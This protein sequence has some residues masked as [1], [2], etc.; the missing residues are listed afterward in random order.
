ME[1]VRIQKVIADSG[2][3][4]RRKAEE[5]IKEKRVK[6]NGRLA[7]IGLKID[8][9][10]DFIVVDGEKI[11]FNRKKEFLY[12]MLHKP[13]GYVTTLADEKGRRCIADL[14]KDIPVRVFPIGRLDINSEGLLLLT[15]DGNFANEIMHPSHHVSKTYR[16]T[17]RPDITDD[18]AA[19]LS[20][21]IVIDGR[22]TAPAEVRVLTKEPNRVVL[23]MVIREGR[24]RQIRK[25]CEEVGLEVARLKRTAMGP[26]KLGMLKPGTYRELRPEE[27]KAIRNAIQ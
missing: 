14:I 22:K 7:T 1:K 2:F 11:H 20:G 24:N 17:V 8:P 23:E 13:R 12:I 5:L 6:V 3:C 15:N 25:M 4:S 26:L 16:V 21:G 19:Q 27:L 9:V 10:K 18:Q